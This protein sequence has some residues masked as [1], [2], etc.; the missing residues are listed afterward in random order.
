MSQFVETSNLNV[1]FMVDTVVNG[2]NLKQ[3]ATL[4]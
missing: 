2:V 4:V 3:L 1:E